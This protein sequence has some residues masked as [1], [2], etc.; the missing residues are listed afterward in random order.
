MQ[1][2][3]MSRP[4]LY[5]DQA[6]PHQDIQHRFQNHLS[7]LCFRWHHSLYTTLQREVQELERNIMMMLEQKEQIGLPARLAGGKAEQMCGL[8]HCCCRPLHV[9][10]EYL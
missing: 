8:Y 7:R 10:A 9:Q 6:R 3:G 4:S 1:N 5:F 2:C